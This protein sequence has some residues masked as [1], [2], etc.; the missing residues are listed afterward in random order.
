VRVKESVRR[1]GPEES[2]V[3]VLTEPGSAATGLPAM[4]LLNSGI[5]HRVGPN[6]VHVAIARRLAAAGHPVL[7]F[8]FSGVGDSPPRVDHLPFEESSVEEARA[9]MDHLRDTTGADRFVLAGICSGADV[10]LATAGRD[11][12]VAGVA[13]VNA[14]RFAASDETF[15][16]VRERAVAKHYRRI[17]TSGS[18]GGKSLA[19]L[20]R[21]RM[22]WGAV[23]RALSS[24][25]PRLAGP[26]AVGSHGL[27]PLLEAGTHIYCLHSEA[28]EG[29]DHLY[30]LAGRDLSELRASPAFRFE[31][32]E[33][34]DHT[35]TM[36]WSQ[37]ALAERLAAWMEERFGRV[38]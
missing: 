5:V 32:V 19:K 18:F 22:P 9:A 17:A 6:R 30:A 2:L 14:R 24:Q 34:A 20:S 15:I 8:D 31:V 35:F 10:A 23:L 12:R 3:G 38:G 4:I 1:L 36:R 28:D 16:A 25:L 26:T 27:R 33:G 29:L 21:G 13:A 11:R 7:R 37:D